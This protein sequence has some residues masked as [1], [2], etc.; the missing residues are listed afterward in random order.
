VEVS[1]EH[2]LEKSEAIRRLNRGIEELLSGPEASKYRISV[3]KKIWTDDTLELE[4]K[5]SKG[6]IGVRLEG[7][8]RVS[9]H[10]VHVSCDLPGIVK[11]FVGEAAVKDAIA[12]KLREILGE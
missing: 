11:T 6:F 12:A 7:R 2:R 3:L 10:R 5:A 8:A 9:D 1:V 4:A